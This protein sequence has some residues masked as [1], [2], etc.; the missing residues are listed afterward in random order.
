LDLF[1]FDAV[2]PVFV[3]GQVEQRFLL[4]PHRGS[5]LDLRWPHAFAEN[6]V[7]LSKLI[8]LCHRDSLSIKI[9]PVGGGPQRALIQGLFESGQFGS[10]SVVA[11]EQ[12]WLWPSLSLPLIRRRQPYSRRARC[13]AH[14]CGWLAFCLSRWTMTFAT[15]SAKSALTGKASSPNSGSPVPLC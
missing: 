6:L 1:C 5:F 7:A 9:A 10:D 12:G 14:L 3:V 15:L 2:Q 8:S 13:A 4:P 11:I